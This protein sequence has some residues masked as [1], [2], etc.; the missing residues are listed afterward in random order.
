MSDR[1]NSEITQTLAG[2]NENFEIKY[3]FFYF[4]EG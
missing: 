3:A 1:V 2:Y 4:N